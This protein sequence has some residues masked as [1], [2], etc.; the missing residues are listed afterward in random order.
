MVYLDTSENSD[1]EPIEAR[2]SYLLPPKAFSLVCADYK[3][4]YAPDARYSIGCKEPLEYF[5]NEMEMNFGPDNQKIN[6][7]DNLHNR[8]E[9]VVRSN[10][11]F[12]IMDV[13]SGSY[14]TFFTGLSY[15][16]FDNSYVNSDIRN[17]SP[18]SGVKKIDV[19][20]ID[21]LQSW[22]YQPEKH[23]EMIAIQGGN[24]V[25][26]EQPGLKLISTNFYE[27]IPYVQDGSIHQLFSFNT[28]F[29]TFGGLYLLE[30]F[31]RFLAQS[32]DHD[33][34]GIGIVSPFEAGNDQILLVDRN[35]QAFS[36]ETVFQL[37]NNIDY[38]HPERHVA[39][40]KDP[41]KNI[42]FP[43]KPF[44]LSKQRYPPY[45]MIYQFDQDTMLRDNRKVDII[46]HRNPNILSKIINE[47]EQVEYFNI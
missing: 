13:G 6:V 27:N 18:Y 15:E 46:Y 16:T 33:R 47:A 24:F 42:R 26:P 43:I 28:V 45:R 37:F 11:I 36:F 38:R 23:F 20:L 1:S 35:H 21:T 7:L 22:G 41:D 29:S 30:Y 31:D 14:A 34:S 3:L 39:W 19:G 44:A 25:I 2:K 4:N 5:K 10:G 32:K 17:R 12:R 40:T 8:V 9:S